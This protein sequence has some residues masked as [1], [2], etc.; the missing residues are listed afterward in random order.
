MDIIITGY[1]G[2]DG[3]L[4]IYENEEY[5]REILEQYNSCFFGVFKTGRNLIE[6]E[7][8]GMKALFGKYKEKGLAEDCSDGGVLKALWNILKL[9]KKGA[10]YSQRLIPVMQQTIEICELY[11]LN[12][13][14][15]DS[16]SCKVWLTDNSGEIISMANS[17]GLPAVII[18]YTEKGLAIKRVDGSETAYLLRPKSDELLKMTKLCRKT[19]D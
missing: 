14:R 18:G 2:F 16:E 5:N 7:R 19:E 4:S 11:E 6:N 3:S 10:S 8:L 9:N 12:P 13:Y 1:A 15:L 17:I